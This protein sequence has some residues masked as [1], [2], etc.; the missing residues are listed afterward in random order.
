MKKNDNWIIGVDFDGTLAVT[1]G[2]YPKIQEPIQE[3]ID[4]LKEQQAK[5]AYLI[6][7]TMRE[8]DVLRQAVNW[9]RE[10][11]LKFDAVN[12]NLP[13]MKECFNNNPR[14]IFCTE[15]ID[16]RNIGGIELILKEIRKKKGE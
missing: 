2:T 6:L 1:R 9:A 11:G 15:Y 13:H 8:E 14:K 12:D 4:Y 10:Q 7:I 3:V 5:G 16:D